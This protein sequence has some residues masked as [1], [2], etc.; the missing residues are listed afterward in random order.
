M[1][2]ASLDL[3]L[4]NQTIQTC[5]E[6]YK[7][8]NLSKSETELNEIRLTTIQKFKPV[9]LKLEDKEM[10]VKETSRVYI[11][12]VNIEPIEINLTFRSASNFDQNTVEN[13]F[14]SDFGLIFASI[15]DANI[16]LK[17]FK[18][19]HIFGTNDILLKTIY[20]YY[21]TNVDWL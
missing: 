2:I 1:Y 15:K 12:T 8:L 20:L 6:M 18:I 19:T 13:N 3:K 16:E 14:F 10:S 7:R 11:K 9:N 21:K 4:D 5:V 17:G